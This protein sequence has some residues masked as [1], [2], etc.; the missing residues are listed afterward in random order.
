MSP[1]GPGRAAVRRVLMWHGIR[2]PESSI[3]VVT[4]AVEL[5]LLL[6]FALFVRGRWTLVVGEFESGKT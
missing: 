6:F 1:R 3:N 4:L 2:R 5:V